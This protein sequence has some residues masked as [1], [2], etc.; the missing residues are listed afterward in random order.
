[1]PGTLA[2]GTNDH[3]APFHCSTRVIVGPATVWTEPTA[4][5][6]VSDVHDTP[7]SDCDCELLVS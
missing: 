3:T 6:K 1:M 7:Y 4:I 2:L 5:Q